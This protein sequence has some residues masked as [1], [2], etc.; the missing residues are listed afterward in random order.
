[1]NITSGK[2]SSSLGQDTEKIVCKKISTSA[3]PIN[4]S[5]FFIL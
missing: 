1:M 3:E 2:P 5:I 4:V